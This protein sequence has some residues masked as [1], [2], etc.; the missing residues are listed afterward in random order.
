MVQLTIQ[1][2]P[3]QTT[4]IEAR[5]QRLAHRVNLLTTSRLLLPSPAP[6]AYTSV[7][8]EDGNQAHST[9]GSTHLI[10]TSAPGMYG[11]NNN[12]RSNAPCGVLSTASNASLE[13]HMTEISKTMLQL[14]Q[15]HQEITNTQQQNHQTMV[16][17]QQQQA[18]AF[19]PLAAAMQQQKY[20][21]MFAA[22]PRYDGNGWDGRDG[23]HPLPPQ[24]DAT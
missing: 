13:S 5:L 12:Q 10:P 7:Q 3:L 4:G 8:S 24:Q 15:A 22:V 21:A 14:A 9:T 2:V 11:H 23:S 18:E 6:P 19:G 20:E 16:N 1:Q 17:V